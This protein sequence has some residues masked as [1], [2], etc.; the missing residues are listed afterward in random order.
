M[1]RIRVI[2]YAGPMDA[3]K[4]LEEDQIDLIDLSPDL[5]HKM[6]LRGSL[7]FDHYLSGD[8]VFCS[9][10]PIRRRVLADENRLAFVKRILTAAAV[11]QTGRFP[12]TEQAEIPLPQSSFILADG[13][14][15]SEAESADTIESVWPEV[16][17]N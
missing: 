9:T 17:D 4:A 1:E 5:Y 8:L 3:L 6:S 13:Y 12:T 7:R 10:I 15:L 16:A 2:P 14:L 11:H